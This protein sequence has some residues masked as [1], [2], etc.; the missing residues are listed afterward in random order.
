MCSLR[1]KLIELRI[2]LERDHDDLTSKLETDFFRHILQ[3]D[4]HPAP[5]FHHREEG[6]IGLGKNLS[7]P[8]KDCHHS[9][10]HE[11]LA[12]QHGFPHGLEERDAHDNIIQ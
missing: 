11:L 7:N 3:T 6:I 10:L 4:I 2:C 12:L 9:S 8:T 5:R 1:L